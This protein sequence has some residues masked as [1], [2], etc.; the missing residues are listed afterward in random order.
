MYQ[1]S[2][3]M[4]VNTEVWTGLK[5]VRVNKHLQWFKRHTSRSS[6]RESSRD[7]KNDSETNCST[8]SRETNEHIFIFFTS[9]SLNQMHLFC[10]CGCSPCGGAVWAYPEGHE[11]LQSCFQ[12]TE[13]R[14]RSWSWWWRSSNQGPL[15][16]HQAGMNLRR[17]SRNFW[18]MILSRSERFPE[19]L[20]YWPSKY[21]AEESAGELGVRQ[22]L[23]GLAW[24][25]RKTVRVLSSFLFLSSV[26]ST[27]IICTCWDTLDREVAL[28]LRVSA[29]HTVSRELGRME[30]KSL[31]DRRCIAS[32][33]SGVGSTGATGRGNSL[34]SNGSSVLL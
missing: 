11:T 23:S 16:C 9:N 30:R 31:K 21:C 33:S 22:A 28:R 13:G 12:W 14:R 26:T 10:C 15:H 7:F 3:K 25:H 17:E 1:W 8:C 34:D 27:L 20:G 4:H 32:V 5:K 6:A 18:S 2:L 29:W 19:G 24:K